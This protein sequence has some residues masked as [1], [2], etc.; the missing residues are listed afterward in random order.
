MGRQSLFVLV[1]LVVG[2]IGLASPLKAQSCP[3]GSVEISRS[4][5]SATI[6]LTCRCS[7]GLWL[8]AGQCRS[9]S[10]AE[11]TAA[12]RKEA[13]QALDATLGNAVVE[14]DE[15][16]AYAVAKGWADAAR[17]GF[18]VST[19]R[20]SRGLFERARS[21]LDR[22]RANVGKDDVAVAYGDLLLIQLQ[23]ANLRRQAGPLARE[24]PDPAF[25]A[26]L[27]IEVQRSV[28]SAELARREGRYDAALS[29]YREARDSAFSSGRRDVQRD[30]GDAEVWTR[31]LKSSAEEKADPALKAQREAQYRKGRE[32]AVAEHSWKL[33]EKLAE[34]GQT[35]RAI[36][37]YAEA[38]AVFQRVRSPMTTVM[39]T[40]VAGIKA[41]TF[42]QSG[43]LLRRMD[44][45]DYVTWTSVMFDALEFAKG[46]PQRSVEYVETL[47]ALDPDNAKYREALGFVRGLAAAKGR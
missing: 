16:Q 5:S 41:G 19:L 25:L 22:S 23:K 44:R 38:D 47:R 32:I 29:Y 10:V 21:E 33:G 40:H 34:A 7:G 4:E 13:S 39:R 35:D 17:G 42:P 9:L 46:D 30:I 27:D 14:I 15:I 1:C 31:A 24:T 18:L 20:A 43:T 3:S 12:F 36:A 28:V 45:A 11:V 8:V 6:T 2:S 26:F 37:L